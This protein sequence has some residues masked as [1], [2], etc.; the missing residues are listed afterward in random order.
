MTDTDRLNA[1]EIELLK[2]EAEAKVKARAES[3]TLTRSELR[4]LAYRRG[5]LDGLGT[6][7]AMLKDARGDVD[8]PEPVVV[9][10]APAGEPTPGPMRCDI[11]LDWTKYRCPCGESICTRYMFDDDVTSWL[12]RHAAHTDGRIV[13]HTTPD[14]DRAYGTH[15]PDVTRP[16][17][18]YTR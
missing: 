13:E 5:Y 12:R 18:D 9:P 2:A 10:A 17:T 15:P 16:L 1:L 14:G 6:A 7:N 4:D 8:P 3:G 11:D